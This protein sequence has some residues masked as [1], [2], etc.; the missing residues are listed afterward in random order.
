VTEALIQTRRHHR[1]VEQRTASGQWGSVAGQGVVV[2]PADLS[3]LRKGL[4]AL[5]AEYC[6][7]LDKLTSSIPINVRL[8]Q[9]VAF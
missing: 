3:K 1:S 6:S 5:Q 7:A 8:L 9:F 2:P 4:E